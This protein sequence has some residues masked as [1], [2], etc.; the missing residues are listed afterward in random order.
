MAVGTAWES[1]RRM[2]RGTAAEVQ[3]TEETQ[4]IPAAGSKLAETASHSG[5]VDPSPD[6]SPAAD[7]PLQSTSAGSPPSGSSTSGGA[8]YHPFLSEANAERLAVTLCRMRGAALKLGQML[9]IQDDTII[10]PQVQKILQRVR[11]NADVMPRKQLEKVLVRELGPDWQKHFQEFQYRPIAAAS[12]GQVHRA[13]LTDGMEVAMKIQYPGVAESIESDLSNLRRVISM[14]SMLPKGLYVDAAIAEA[15]KE[16]T[17]ECDYLSEARHQRHFQC[18]IRDEPMFI[19]PDVIPE[20]STSRVLTSTLVKGLTI[21]QICQMDQFTRNKVAQKLLELCLRELFEFRYMQTD[22]NWSNF[23]YDHKNNKLILLDFGACRSFDKSFVD[24]YI[25][26]VYG[27]AVGDRQM[28]IDASIKMGFLTGD[29]TEEMMNA[30]AS[31]ATIVGE[32][33]AQPAVFDFSTQRMT[34]RVN[35][36]VPAMLKH[37]LTAPPPESYSLHRK[38]SGSF[39]LCFKLGAKI[40]CH[41]AFMRIWERYSFD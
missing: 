3:S 9:S 34:R 22:P 6:R 36:L 28:I 27:S 8:L 21:D 4:S 17:L 41:D 14:T 29:E 11:D 33:F 30:H 5:A 7:R 13:V 32:P 37:R 40:Q 31:A 15:K 39:L 18:L 35:E 12:I 16:L 26:L 1:T 24:E 2:W 38:L 25:K 23:F 19:V 10:P 20:L